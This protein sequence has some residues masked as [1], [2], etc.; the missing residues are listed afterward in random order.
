M[1]LISH[2]GNLRGPNTDRENHP[3]YIQEALDVGYDVEVDVWLIQGEW[4]FGHSAPQWQVDAKFLCDCGLWLHCKNIEAFTFL[5]ECGQNHHYFWHETDRYTLTSRHWVW[6]YPG[7][8]LPSKRGIAVL[9]ELS[10]DWFTEEA[11]G[12]CSDWI[13]VYK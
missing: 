5:A 10:P 11:E 3:D 6:T 4:Y 13:E 1:R 2:R 9:P 12:I 7:S 8:A